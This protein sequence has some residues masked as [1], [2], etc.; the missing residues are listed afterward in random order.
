M[1]RILLLAGLWE[2]RTK[3]EIAQQL[4]GLYQSEG[5][6]GSH[7]KL[8]EGGTRRWQCAHHRDTDARAAHD[9]V[10]VSTRTACTHRGTRWGVRVCEVGGECL[11]IEDEA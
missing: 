6:S 1:Q 4:I 10:P 11:A 3:K 9:A 8:S 5:L 2:D 7:M